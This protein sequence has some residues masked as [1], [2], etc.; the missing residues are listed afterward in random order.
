MLAAVLTAFGC[1]STPAGTEITRERAIEIA[2]ADLKFTPTSIDAR[3]AVSGSRPVWRV[4]FR[5]RLPG[6]PPMLFET[7]IV[8]VDRAN[9][10]IVSVT[11]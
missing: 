4:E 8:E 10:A 6:Q 5:G 1:R 2:R 3:R 7:R 11:R 9:G